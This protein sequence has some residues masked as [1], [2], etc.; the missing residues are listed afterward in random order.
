V[1]RLIE[2]MDIIPPQYWKKLKNTD[3]IWEAKI[4]FGGNIFSI[5]G[6]ESKGSFVVLT[7]SFAKKTQKTPRSEIALAGTKEKAVPEGESKMSDLKKYIEKRK[8]TNPEFAEG[9]DEGYENFRIGIMLK[10]G[11]AGGGTDTG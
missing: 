7:N 1:L 5:L 4:Q 11:T 10:T 9:F 2:D 6:F 8:A 3:D